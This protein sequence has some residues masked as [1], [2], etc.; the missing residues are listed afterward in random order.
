VPLFSGFGAVNRP[1]AVCGLLEADE[2]LEQCIA[3]AELVRFEPEGAGVVD[4]PYLE[5]P[6]VLRGRQLRRHPSLG[7]LIDV[8]PF[9]FQDPMMADIYRVATIGRGFLAV[10]ARPALKE[11]LHESIQGLIHDY[12]VIVVSLLEPA[13]EAELGL[14]A[15]REACER[16]GLAFRS[17]P[18]RD[19]ATP[20]D[21]EAVARLSQWAHA[22]IAA[23]HNLVFH[24]RAGIGR[25]GMMAA[26]VLL[27]EGLSAREAFERISAARGLTIPDTPGQL[28]WVE[29]N[30]ETIIRRT[31]PRISRRGDPRG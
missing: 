31:S 16:Q 19:R 26:S 20:I 1:D 8:D 9:R 4:T 6:W 18:I 21:A 25:S 2:F 17:F 30:R 3:E 22:R 23:G 29:D 28:E 12:V 11:S 13:E 24:C 27:H 5:V 7:G 15:E 14:A 10:M